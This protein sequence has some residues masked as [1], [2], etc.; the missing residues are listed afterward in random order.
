MESLPPDEQL[1][2]NDEEA[3][4]PDEISDQNEI[5]PQEH[6]AP[7][8]NFTAPDATAEDSEQQEAMPST[9]LGHPDETVGLPSSARLQPTT[10]SD[11]NT[12]PQVIDMMQLPY[13]IRKDL[14]EIHI[15]AH[16]YAK[17]PAS[18]LVSINGHV[19]REGSSL[20]PG[21]KLEEITA[22]G[23]IFS[24]EG[25]HFYVGVF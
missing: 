21:L 18:R 3:A 15:A 14:P 11:G 1:E 23:V 17:Q 8:S 22:D 16:V 24:Y 2:M 9:E 20:Q 13:S 10:T 6:N 5:L 4:P 19:L 12:K 25:Y 7:R